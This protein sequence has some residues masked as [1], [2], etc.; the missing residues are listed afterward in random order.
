MSILFKIINGILTNK[1][2]IPTSFWYHCFKRRLNGRKISSK[3]RELIY[4]NIDK[5][6][7]IDS[8]K[9]VIQDVL[10]FILKDEKLFIKKNNLE[11]R[12][13]ISKRDIFLI[14]FFKKYIYILLF[15][16]H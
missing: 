7:L 2:T 12:Y 16:S 13:I 8:K 1:N 5:S 4:N 9:G 14:K 11:T 3:T 6:Y 10:S 15:F